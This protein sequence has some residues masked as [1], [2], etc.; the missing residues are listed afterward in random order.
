MFSLLISCESVFHSFGLLHVHHGHV[1]RWAPLLLDNRLLSLKLA[2]SDADLILVESVP[3]ESIPTVIKRKPK[4]LSSGQDKRNDTLNK[5]QC[6]VS[7]V[8]SA[9]VPPVGNGCGNICSDSEK[10]HGEVPL[11]LG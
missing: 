7:W 8:G 4:E 6:P 3:S 11:G 9:Q 10:R 2:L 5:D 1:R